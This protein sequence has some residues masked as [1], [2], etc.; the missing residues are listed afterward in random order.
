MA[1][2]K[3][4]KYPEFDFEEYKASEGRYSIHDY[5]A[6]LHHKHVSNLM[7]NILP[8][9]VLYMTLLWKLSFYC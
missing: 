9:E 2:V 5:P 4:I 7:K 3:R 6:M 8:K 1:C